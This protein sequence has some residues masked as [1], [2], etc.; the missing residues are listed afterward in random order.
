VFLKLDWS[1][2]MKKKIQIMKNPPFSD[3][4]YHARNSTHH[5]ALAIHLSKERFHPTS[6]VVDP[7]WFQCGSGSSILGQC[8]SILDT[9]L[10]PDPG[11][12]RPKI[13]KFYS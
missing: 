12:C 8:G 4:N 6:I 9:I 11:F 2:E 1:L 5:P 3:S 10:D 13:I 7:H